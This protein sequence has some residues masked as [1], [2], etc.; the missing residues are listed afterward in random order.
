MDL[1][2]MSRNRDYL[3]H[4]K[5]AIDLYIQ[6]S[7]RYTILHPMSKESFL[8]ELLLNI[9]ENIPIILNF[10]LKKEYFIKILEKMNLPDFIDK[11]KLISSKIEFF[12]MMKL[13]SRKIEIKIIIKSDNLSMRLDQPF[14]SDEIHELICKKRVRKSPINTIISQAMSGLSSVLIN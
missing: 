7:N 8:G 9:S 2:S 4:M 3:K 12:V 13:E 10:K 5:R 11:S 6:E 1:A 14:E